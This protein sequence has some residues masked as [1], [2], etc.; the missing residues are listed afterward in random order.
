M[1][2]IATR[3]LSEFVGAEVVG[4]D[5][6]R[7]LHDDDLPAACLQALEE[8]GVLLFR[9]LNIDDEVQIAFGRK[10]GRLAQIPGYRSPEVMEIS[11]DPANPNAQYFPSNDHWHFDG[12]MDDIPAKAA[13]MSARVITDEGGETEFASTYVAYDAL[14][15]AEKDRFAGLRILHTF[16]SIQRRTYQD[17]TPEQLEDWASWEDRE[18]PLVWE[19]ESGRRSL[20]FGASAAR[21]IGM[22]VGESRALLADLERR[23]TAPERVLRHSW[24][25]GDLVV[26]DNLGLVHRACP[27]DRTQPRRMHRT[28]LA[29]E[30]AI[31]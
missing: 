25:V 27:F 22:D 26:W 5:V 19:H 9:E 24:S 18:H 8:N 13:L 31:R 15:E 17:P 11:F 4:V 16:E 12:S 20:V 10:L 3:K 6:D 23:S 29:G 30:E 28:T 14:S 21:V 7:L 1:A 2:V